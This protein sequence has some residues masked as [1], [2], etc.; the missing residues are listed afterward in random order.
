LDA[1]GWGELHSLTPTLRL[2]GGSGNAF[3][4]YGENF[5]ILPQ[6]LCARS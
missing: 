3:S 2:Q 6:N 1:H 5:F 4:T